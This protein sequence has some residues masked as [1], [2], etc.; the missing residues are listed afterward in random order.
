LVQEEKRPADAGLLIRFFMPTSSP[1]ELL[2]IFSV[3]SRIGL[4]A[5]NFL[6]Q[7]IDDRGSEQI[8]QG[9]QCRSDFVG[10]LLI[11]AWMREHI[12]RHLDYLS[13]R[14]CVEN[15]TGPA[16]TKRYGACGWRLPS[17]ANGYQ[18]G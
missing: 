16:P 4:F 9:I 12:Y 3:F 1:I 8:E 11:L 6:P 7:L 10:S 2:S 15:A 17:R 13:V 14:G 5:A 18:F